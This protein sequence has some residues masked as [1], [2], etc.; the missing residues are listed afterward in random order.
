[1]GNPFTAHPHAVGESYFEHLGF[2]LRFGMKMAL[3]GLTALVH[4][5]FPFLFTSTAG[6][7][8]DE[9]QAMR[10]QSPGRL[11]RER[12]ARTQQQQIQQ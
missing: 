1:M 7:I 2:A 5:V 8:N 12:Q 6:R 4:A 11:K 10:L 9:L 3:G